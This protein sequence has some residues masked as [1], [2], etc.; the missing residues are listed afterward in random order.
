[1]RTQMKNPLII[2]IMIKMMI[3]IRDRTRL[4]A[5]RARD[6]YA[7][8][9]ENLGRNRM[10]ALHFRASRRGGDARFPVSSRPR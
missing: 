6:I 9:R 2:P 1:M 7:A 8:P 4:V 10:G 3:M 5:T